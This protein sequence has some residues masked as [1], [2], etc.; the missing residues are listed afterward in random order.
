VG[1]EQLGGEPLG[2]RPHVPLELAVGVVGGVL[3]DLVGGLEALAHPVGDERSQ[4]VKGFRHPNALCRRT[5]KL[6]SAGRWRAAES[7]EI[8]MR[9]ASAE[10][11]G[12]PTVPREN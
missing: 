3:D 12:S 1:R 2:L 5:H 10:A 11:T 8:G 4:V 6:S 7:R 9:P